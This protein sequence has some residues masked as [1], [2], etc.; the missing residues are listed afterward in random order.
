MKTRTAF[1]AMA[2][3][4][5][6]PSFAA[7][8]VELVA[9][10]PA[11]SIEY[12]QTVWQVNGRCDFNPGPRTVTNP[13]GEYYTCNAESGQVPATKAAICSISY[14]IKP[15]P[16]NDTRSQADSF[17]ATQ[18]P[19]TMTDTQ[20]VK[21]YLNKIKCT[22]KS[23]QEMGPAAEGS[24]RCVPASYVKDPNLTGKKCQ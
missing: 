14:G 9:P 2:L 5:S 6:T 24:F 23:S 19:S 15:D 21:N 18:R 17:C 16:L 1:W 7:T 8:A 3:A 4:W 12:C 20:L 11:G 10:E 13:F 22:F